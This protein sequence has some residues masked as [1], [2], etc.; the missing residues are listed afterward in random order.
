[1]FSNFRG[2]FGTYMYYLSH[3]N[4]FRNNLGAK[5]FIRNTSQRIVG[6]TEITTMW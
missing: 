5:K 4:Q 3:D 6:L 2:A 1:M